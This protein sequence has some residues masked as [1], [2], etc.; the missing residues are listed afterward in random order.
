MIL[1]IIEMNARPAK[2]KEL[3]QTLHAIIQQIRNEK[4]L[5]KCSACQDIENKNIFSLIEE[6]TMQQDLDNHLR[7]ELFTVLLGAKNIMSEPLDI[8][9][10]AVS[11]TTGMEALNV[12]RGKTHDS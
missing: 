10:N 12:A 6:W 2:R 7:S 4:G 8:K 9:F 5:T 1:A 11:S 3:L